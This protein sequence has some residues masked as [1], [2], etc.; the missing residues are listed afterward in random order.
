M[1]CHQSERCRGRIGLGS[2][3]SGRSA[4]PPGGV[5]PESVAAL[6]AFEERRAILGMFDR[7]AMLVLQLPPMSY[8]ARGCGMDVIQFWQPVLCEEDSDEELVE[9]ACSGIVGSEEERA[10]LRDDAPPVAQTVLPPVER[11]EP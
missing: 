11:G 4:P 9:A 2:N 8:G 1:R 10:M 7:S 3:R 5:A 6:A